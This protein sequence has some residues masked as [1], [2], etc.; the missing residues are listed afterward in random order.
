MPRVKPT[1]LWWDRDNISTTWIEPRSITCLPLTCDTVLFTCDT[2]L[3]TCDATE[4]NCDWITT[5]YTV[6]RYDK[7]VEDINKT[8]L[9]DLSWSQVLWISWDEENKI[10][11]FWS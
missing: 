4:Y 3:I 6:P 2:T 10:K 9:F 1:T 7:Y 5:D 8:F 11:T